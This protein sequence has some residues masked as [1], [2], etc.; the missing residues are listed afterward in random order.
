MEVPAA[1]LLA[2]EDV[3]PEHAALVGGKALGLSRLARGKLPVPPVVVVTTDAFLAVIE[4]NHLGELLERAGRG[5]DLDAARALRERLLSARLPV[6][7]D[8]ALAVHLRRLGGRVAVRSSSLGEDGRERSYAGMHHTTLDVA[9][10]EVPDALRAAWA[11]LF[12]E[13]VLAYRGAGRSG[14]LGMAVVIQRMVHPISSGV[15]FTINPMTGSWREMVV[16]GTWGLGEGLMSGQVTPHWYLVRRPRKAPRPVQAVLSRVQLQLMQQD[17]PDIPTRW[18]LR[19]DGH[20]GPEP[21]PSRLRGQPTLEREQLLRLCRLGL[22]TEGTLG[23]PLDVEWALGD[24]GRLWLLQARPITS[25]A[26]PRARTDVL[27]TRRFFG[28][29]WSG[30]ATPLGWSLIAPTLDWFIAYP[31][32]QARY[33]GGGPAIKLVHSRPYFNVTVFRHLAFKLPGAP[34]PEFMLEFMPPEEARAWRSR[35]AVAPGT[36]VYLAIFRETWRDRRWERFRWNPFTN[37]RRWD[38]FEARLSDELPRLGRAPTSLGDAQRLVDEQQALLRDYISVHITSLLFANLFY[39]LLDGALAAWVPE[40]SRDLMRDLATCPPGNRTLQVN[41]ALYALAQLATEDDLAALESAGA[42]TGTA[43]F[44]AL[45]EFL[46]TYG[47]RADGSW[48]VF[49]P[50]WA[51][52]P[53]LLAPLVRSARD[54]AD[55][56]ERSVGQEGAYRKAAAELRTLLR[57][58]TVRRSMVQ[59]LVHY[60]RRYLLLRE[61]QRFQFDRLLHVTQRTLRWMGAELARDDRLDH[62]ED[63]T[64]LA[65]DEVKGLMDGSLAAPTARQLV[66]ERRAQ[67]DRDRAAEPPTFLAGGDVGIAEPGGRRLQGLGISSGRYRGRVRVVRTLSEG[68]KLR[69]G[70]VLVTRS[71]DPAWTPLFLTAGAVVLELGSRLSHGAVVAREYHVPAVVNIEGATRRLEDGQ[72]ITVDGHRGVVWVHSDA[73]DARQV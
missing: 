72:E 32:T 59:V 45:G 31:K 63:V 6:A 27:W 8:A 55:P 14:R 2:L 21:V 24:D 41:Q 36:A 49:S 4:Y 22:L 38:E 57:D 19:A 47:H 1:L 12:S 18:V 34:P 48:E 58:N 17:L 20:A 7:L 3:G 53:E 33:L 60:T 62:A 73:S 11:S 30:L 64:L 54:G 70:E 15:L 10:N 28:E 61:N 52:H 43:F 9:H 42:P 39:Q 23:E 66:A 46:S 16:E 40:R 51:D 44:Q 29:R 56:A 13:A 5:G 37:H 71:V 68:G 50:R 65:W 26:T 67:R 69:P 25:T 35:F